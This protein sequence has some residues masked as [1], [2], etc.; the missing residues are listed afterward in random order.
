MVDIDITDSEAS[1]SDEDEYYRVRD[2]LDSVIH[3]FQIERI[4]DVRVEDGRLEFLTRWRD[5]NVPTWEPFSRF[6]GG[7]VNE[8]IFL[9]ENDYPDKWVIVE[10]CEFR[11]STRKGS[12]LTSYRLR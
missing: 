3:V 10:E 5:W 4:E 11:V 6:P 8:Q 1:T 7:L 12:Q 9:F 2:I